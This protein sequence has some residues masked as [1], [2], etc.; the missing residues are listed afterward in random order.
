MIGGTRNER[1]YPALE[2]VLCN[3]NYPQISP[4]HPSKGDSCEDI[5]LRRTNLGSPANP[6]LPIIP[7]FGLFSA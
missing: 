3:L 2:P 7:R 5:R 4:Y 1:V 6:T